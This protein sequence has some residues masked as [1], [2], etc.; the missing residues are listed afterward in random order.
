MFQVSLDIF[1]EVELLG[2]KVV[3]FIILG[4]TLYC[5]SQWLHTNQHSGGETLDISYS[6]FF[7]AISHC[8]R[9]TKGKQMESHQLKS[10]FHS[11][12]NQQQNEKTAHCWGN[13]FA[14]DISDKGLIFKIY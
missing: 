3:P 4:E 12:G 5:F 13:I 1:P 8:A 6:M 7:S 11:E 10:F 2:R 9:E 14:N